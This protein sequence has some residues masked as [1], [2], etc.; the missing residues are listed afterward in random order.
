MSLIPCPKCGVQVPALQAIDPG[1][2]AQ[3][4]EAGQEGL[5]SEVCVS[6]IAQLSASVGR[7]GILLAREKAKEQNR[8]LM[9][10]NRVGLI[11]A[12]RRAMSEKMF[13]EAAMQYEK[14]IRTLEL[15]FE[16]KTGELRPEMFKDSAR[17][18]ELTVITSVLWDLM[19]IYDTSDKY[20]ER[21]TKAAQMLAMFVRFTPIY[22]DIM[23]KAES[24]SK[25]AKHP[26]V[27]KNFLKTSGENRPRCFIATAAFE[28]PEA[29]EIQYLSF[30]RDDYLAH[31]KCGQKF[32]QIYYRISPRIA[33]LLDKHPYT[34]PFVRAALRGMIFCVKAVLRVL[35][36]Q[37]R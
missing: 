7:G 22:P 23:R 5:P 9:W 17:T 35:S 28:Y 13:P 26:A 24:F 27:F 37:T 31:S 10:K 15:V 11:K 20:A 32:I 29:P 16:V 18:T 25:S 21:Q 1:L 8:L 14:Y 33:C 19:R 12:A 34:K 4:K 6:C 2:S 36:L 3:L 30:W